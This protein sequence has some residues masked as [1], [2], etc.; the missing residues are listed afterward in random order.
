MATYIDGTKLYIKQ[1]E[2][3]VQST[4]G[5]ATNPT[6]LH[7]RANGNLLGDIPVSWSDNNYHCAYIIFTPAQ[8]ADSVGISVK[9]R[10]AYGTDQITLFKEWVKL[11]TSP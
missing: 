11:V 10:F 1:V 3:C 9:L 4:N 2:F 5:A 6:R 8:W 7:V